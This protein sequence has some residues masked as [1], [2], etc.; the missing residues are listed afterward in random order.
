MMTA[1][2]QTMY[3]KV[4]ETD[5]NTSAEEQREIKSKGWDIGNFPPRGAF[6]AQV[7]AEVDSMQ[8]QLTR[9]AERGELSEAEA[10]RQLH[11]FGAERYE[12]AMRELMALYDVWKKQ[13][14]PAAFIGE[15]YRMSVDVDGAQQD[16]R[17][18]KRN[19]GL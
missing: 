5:Y 12:K 1:D 13:Y 16:L 11:V 15:L 17:N 3:R 4:L 7:D 14:F 19:L 8:E 9:R 6:M 10:T 2:F 18:L